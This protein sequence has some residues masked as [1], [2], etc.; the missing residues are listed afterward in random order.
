MATGR[1]DRRQLQP[2]RV[3]AQHAAPG[4]GGR[5]GQLAGRGCRT[6]GQVGGL[7]V[8]AL[9]LA[10]QSCPEQQ[11]GQ[12]FRQLR[13][14]GPPV[15]LVP[16]PAQGGAQVVDVVVEVA[17]PGP[18]GAGAGHQKPLGPVTGPAEMRGERRLVGR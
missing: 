6:V 16:T 13:P 12:G 11:G 10:G 2:E 5:Q 7:L 4:D 14:L 17:V 15:R 18:A 8:A 3:L 9:R 1:R